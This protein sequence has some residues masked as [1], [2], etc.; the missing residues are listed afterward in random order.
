MLKATLTI[1][2]NRGRVCPSAYTLMQAVNSS[3]RLTSVKYKK[4]GSRIWSDISTDA[5]LDLIAVRIK[6][7]RDRT[8]LAAQGAVKVNRTE[9][10]YMYAGNLTNEESY[11]FSKC[12][13][14][15]GVTSLSSAGELFEGASARALKDVLGYP[16]GGNPVTDIGD[17][18]VICIIGANPA[19]SH[20]VA[21]GHVVHAAE[22]GKIIITADPRITETA[23]ISDVYVPLY[24]GTDGAFINGLINYI[25]QHDVYKRE[26]VLEYT[27][28]SYLVS[29][30]F[31]FD[32]S[33]GVFSGY[34]AAARAYTDTSS[35]KYSYDERGNPE[36][37]E[38]MHNPNCVLQIMK[39]HYARY[40]P[41]KSR[42]NNRL[43]KR[44]FS[45]GGGKNR[46][47]GST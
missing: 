28:A 25:L 4:A 17:A 46:F 24:P 47:D 23:S 36:R 9:G 41:E 2:I 31:S 42:I 37:D 6:D 21:F 33:A 39:R 26:Y 20:P 29:K 27:D 44:D 15:L 8:F 13:R 7:V 12:A 35:W 43:F 18:D 16:A 45:R 38:D 11:L 30:D 14:L 3:K 32:E 19:V 5:A 34:N 1:P 22:A 40:T 10:L